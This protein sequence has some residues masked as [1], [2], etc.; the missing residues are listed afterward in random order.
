MAGVEPEQGAEE[1][2][3]PD[4]LGLSE[5]AQP[6]REEPQTQHQEKV[7]QHGRRLCGWRGRSHDQLAFPPLSEPHEP[8]QRELTALDREI[9]KQTVQLREWQMQELLTLRQQLHALEREVQQRHQQE[10]T[11]RATAGHDE[12]TFNTNRPPLPPFVQ[13]F[14]KLKETAHECQAAQLKKLREACEK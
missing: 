14:Q 3:Q 1:P 13:A 2:Q 12:R 10:V 4:P 7:S 11:M 5:E 9:E 8:A 6:D